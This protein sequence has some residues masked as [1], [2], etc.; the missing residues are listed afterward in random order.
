MLGAHVER[1]VRTDADGVHIS[2]T[3]SFDL[4]VFRVSC[5]RLLVAVVLHVAGL[6]RVAGAFPDGDN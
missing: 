5:M 3:E 2:V 6:S 1:S 4:S